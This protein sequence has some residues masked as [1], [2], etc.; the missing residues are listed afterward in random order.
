MDIQIERS[1]TSTTWNVL[2]QGTRVTNWYNKQCRSIFF[3]KLLNAIESYKGLYWFFLGFCEVY[4][5]WGKTLELT[6][7]VKIFGHSVVFI[8]R[9]LI[10]WKYSVKLLRGYDTDR[11]IAPD[12]FAS[13]YW[14]C[15]FSPCIFN[16][17][18]QIS[19]WV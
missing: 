3:T 6:I 2:I 19:W 7:F 15:C 17:L 14:F 18:S 13:Y 5:V 12:V 10:S 9:T 11:D 4:K 1:N 8:G 16:V